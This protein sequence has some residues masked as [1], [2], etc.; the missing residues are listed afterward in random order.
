MITLDNHLYRKAIQA[1]AIAFALEIEGHWAEFGVASG[2]S[3]RVFLNSL[4]Q[5]YNLYL[6]DSFE[7]LP[8]HWFKK[9]EKGKYACDIPEFEN[10]Q[11][12]IIKGLYEDTLPQWSN[13]FD[14]K[15]SLVHIDCDLYSSTKC[16]LKHIRKHLMVGSVLL[17]DEFDLYKA[18]KNNREDRAFLEFTEETGIKF[19]HTHAT[20]GGQRLIIVKSLQ[21]GSYGFGSIPLRLLSP[22]QLREVKSKMDKLDITGYSCQGPFSLEGKM[23]HL[24]EIKNVQ[25]QR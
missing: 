19:K 9:L 18:P 7:G 24:L 5:G 17:F 25:S 3:A 20:I 6:F 22:K 15:L 23:L 12:V 21:E 16:V 1:H 2:A 13:S 4:P 11:A 14:G 8:E 10:E